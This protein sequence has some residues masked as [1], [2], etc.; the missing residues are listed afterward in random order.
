MSLLRKLYKLTSLRLANSWPKVSLP[1]ITLV[2]VEENGLP[3]PISYHPHLSVSLPDGSASNQRLILLHNL[4]Q[5][6][7]SAKT[8]LYDKKQKVHPS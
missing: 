6:H 7:A 4:N 3:H 5:G 2:R 1:E 8:M